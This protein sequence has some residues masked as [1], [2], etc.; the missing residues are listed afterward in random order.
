MKLRFAC[1]AVLSLALSSCSTVAPSRPAPVVVTP[2]PRVAPRCPDCGRVERI[3]IIH[4]VRATA[5]GGAVLGGI[6]GGVLSEPAKNAEPAKTT[7]AQT[8][9]RITLRM[10]DG[11]RLVVHQNLIAPKLR[12]GSFIRFTNG[13]VMLL[14]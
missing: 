1:L 11:R 7:G 6:V 2:A 8:S 9:Y 12:V 13:R 10:D 4:G 14:R 5:K 3:E